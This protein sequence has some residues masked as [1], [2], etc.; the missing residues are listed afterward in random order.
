MFC[1]KNLVSKETILKEGPRRVQ[2]EASAINELIRRLFLSHT[3][4]PC[5]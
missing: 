3:F 5:L 1:V 4:S 2:H